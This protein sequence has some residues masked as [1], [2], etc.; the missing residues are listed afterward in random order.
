M[1]EVLQ[2]ITFILVRSL[3][4]LFEITPVRMAS[5]AGG[6]L[7]R[8]VGPWLPITKIARKNLEC[9][10]P[11]RAAEHEIIICDM[12]DNFGRV[13]AEYPHL[14]TIAAGKGGAKIDI[15]GEEHFQTFMHMERGGIIVSA[16]LANWEFGPFAARARGMPVHVVYRPPNNILVDR[17]LSSARGRGVGSS[18]AK[19]NAGAREI[20]KLIKSKSYIA[21]L[22][23]QKMNDGI[24]VEFMGRPAMTAPAAAQLAIKFQVPI[25]MVRPMRLNGIHFRWEIDEPFVP[26]VDAD[27]VQI[28]QK[29]TNRIADWVSENPQEWLWV[30]RR[31]RI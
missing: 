2:F 23:D 20:V 26:P 29:I 16:H 27:A 8:T 13:F 1:R 3:Y 17:L 22:L 19:G 14:A 21:M 18:I 6:W 5:A 11:K 15:V 10:L 7:G 12:W 9:I 4:F 28:T 24:E 25:L 30:H 31:W